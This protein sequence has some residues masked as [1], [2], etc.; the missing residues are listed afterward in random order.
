MSDKIG[1][2]DV[3]GFLKG[4]LDR[5]SMELVIKMLVENSC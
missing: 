2:E 5:E 4:S 3:V 1:L